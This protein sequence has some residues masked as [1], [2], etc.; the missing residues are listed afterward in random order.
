MVR[1]ISRMSVSTKLSV[2][3]PAWPVVPVARGGA[4]T[5][6]VTT[7]RSS[8]A[9]GRPPSIGVLPLTRRSAACSSLDCS[10][11]SKPG[12]EGSWH[13]ASTISAAV[14]AATR[15]ARAADIIVADAVALAGVAPLGCR[16]VLAAQHPPQPADWADATQ[17][18]PPADAAQRVPRAAAEFARRRYRLE[19]AQE[20][21]RG[22]GPSWAARSWSRSGRLKIP[23]AV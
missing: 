1:M 4:T 9:L 7:P 16:P 21:G 5:G 10:K 23:R 20:A 18:L 13:P 22:S 11:A 6:A 12:C 17:R 3:S 2:T 8:K 15:L 19:V 14:E